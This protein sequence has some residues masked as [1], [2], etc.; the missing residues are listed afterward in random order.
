MTWLVLISYLL[1]KMYIVGTQKNHLNE[2][3]LLSDQNIFKTDELEN[4]EKSQ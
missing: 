2:T 1:T 3:V 4:N